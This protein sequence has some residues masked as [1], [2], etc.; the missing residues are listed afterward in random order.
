MTFASWKT[1]S[2]GVSSIVLGLVRGYFAWR[3]KDLDEESIT[4]TMTLVL[5]GV[6]LLFARDN[7]VTSEQ[8]GLVPATKPTNEEIKPS[9]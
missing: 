9:P 2:A 7:N 1:T 8:A 3:K 6:G 5:T 4:T